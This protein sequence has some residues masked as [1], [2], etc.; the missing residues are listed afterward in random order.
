MTISE[1]LTIVGIR[2]VAALDQHRKLL[3]A[4]ES[5]FAVRF[6]ACGGGELA[7]ALV[8]VGED[9][10]PSVEDN[11]SR[12]ESVLVF[13]TASNTC[14]FV[15]DVRVLA[16]WG[17]DRRLRDTL[18]RGQ[19]VGL[20]IRPEHGDEP[21]ASCGSQPVWLRR[22]G[23][24]RI[25]RISAPPPALEDGMTLMDVL[26][27]RH[28]LGLIALVQFLR[29]L[30]SE[31]W[32]KPGLRCAFVI[33]D[34][35]LRRDR[36]GY[37]NYRELVQHADRH[38]YHIAM[39]MIPLDARRSSESAA[40]VFRTRSDR[41][42]LVMHGNDHYGQEMASSKGFR[43]A[44]AMAAQA[45]RRVSWFEAKTS[46]VVDRVMMPPH[47]AWSRASA[48]ALGALDYA[49]LCSWRSFPSTADAVA[50]DVLSGWTPATF[51]EG[52]AVVPR[53]PWWLDRTAIA[54]RAFVDHPLILYGH[55]DDLAS[56]LEPLAAAAE[57]VNSFGDVE[58]TSVG[59][60]VRGNH[61]VRIAN[62]TIAVRPWGRRL[63]VCVPESCRN[64]TVVEPLGPRSTGIKGWSLAGVEGPLLALGQRIPVTSRGREVSLRLHSN[65]ET[66]PRDVASPSRSV[67]AIARRRLTEARD[68]LAT[69]G[70]SRT[71][72]RQSPR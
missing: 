16:H 15:G 71:P 1:S 41:L 32:S 21:L 46:L 43:S 24:R 55:H 8:V 66:D 40:G 64:L 60:I 53:F 70:R 17:V 51:V 3:A 37:V 35:N 44:L 30:E 33:D 6:V 62:G 56:G 11:D 29:A 10:L 26:H 61:E 48:R 23:P 5:A 67:S 19:A 36:Y 25:E 42:S 63:Q 2:P 58:W 20:P 13:A 52:C 27:G 12:T 9:N 54:L 34:P 45:S 65:W 39:A 4:L 22:F 69:V 49:G 50:G 68:R 28:S 31:R 18:L 72:G 59:E 47:E 14:S 57:L 38:G 7:S